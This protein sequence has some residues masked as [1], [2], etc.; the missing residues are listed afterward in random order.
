MKFDRTKN[1]LAEVVALDAV[2]VA[3]KV[4]VGVDALVGGLLLHRDLGEESEGGK[5]REVEDEARG[6]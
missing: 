3:A 4:L 5:R 6:R 1:K 2:A